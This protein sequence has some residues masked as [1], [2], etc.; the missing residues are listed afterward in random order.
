MWSDPSTLGGT[1]STDLTKKIGRTVIDASASDPYILIKFD[2]GT[3]LLTGVNPRSNS[4][5]SKLLDVKGALFNGGGS[6]GGGSGGSGGGKGTT[7]K[8]SAY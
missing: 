2:D 5:S 7:K 8:S 1:A 6:G 3:F 4:L